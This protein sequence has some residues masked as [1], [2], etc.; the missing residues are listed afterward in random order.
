[1]NY[2]LGSG[3][4]YDSELASLTLT[5]DWALK[6][7]IT[8]LLTALRRASTLPLI[9]IGSGGSFTTSAFT[10]DCHQYFCRRLAKAITPLELMADVPELA[11]RTETYIGRRG[12]LPSGFHFICG[13]E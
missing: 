8:I 6:A 5:Y 12:L 13:I 10:A 4:L 9:A 1:M 7:D 2:G 3:K 11:G